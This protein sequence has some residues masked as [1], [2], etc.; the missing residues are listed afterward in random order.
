[1]C[2]GPVPPHPLQPGTAQPL[3][4]AAHSSVVQQ[5]LRRKAWA[6]SASPSGPVLRTPLQWCG[7][8]KPQGRGMTGCDPWAWGNLLTCW[9]AQA[10]RRIRLPQLVRRCRRRPTTTAGLG[11]TCAELKYRKDHWLKLFVVGTFGLSV[12]VDWAR[13][14]QPLPSEAEGQPLRHKTVFPSKKS[15]EALGHPLQCP[16]KKGFFGWGGPQR[17]C[18]H[19]VCGSGI[20]SNVQHVCGAQGMGLGWRS[21]PAANSAKGPPTVTPVPFHSAETRSRGAQPSCT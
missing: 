12:P 16:V 4:N 9:G 18:V 21:A 19:T 17:T 5:H 20:G 6:H 7:T 8:S 1:M 13:R 14:G 2:G 3:Q 15:P 10:D 11:D